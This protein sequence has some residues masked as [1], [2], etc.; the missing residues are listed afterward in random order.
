[1]Y[2]CTMQNEQ[3]NPMSSFTFTS[4]F[5]LKLQ[6]KFNSVVV[7]KFGEEFSNSDL[8]KLANRFYSFYFV[9][10]INCYFPDVLI[11]NFKKGA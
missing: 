3:I 11:S 1:V 6:E 4:G 9:R 10:G 8:Q 5:E 7:A 2:V